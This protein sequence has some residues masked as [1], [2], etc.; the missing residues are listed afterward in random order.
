MMGRDE[1]IEWCQDLS[2]AGIVLN[3]QISGCTGNCL[4]A[5]VVQ[6]NDQLITNSSPEKLTQLLIESDSL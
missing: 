5:P 6:W 2:A 3:Q 1:L 4:E